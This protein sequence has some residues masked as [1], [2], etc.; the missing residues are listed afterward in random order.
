MQKIY[1]LVHICLLSNFWPLLY[2]PY[3]LNMEQYVVYV[4]QYVTKLLFCVITKIN[5]R[6]MEN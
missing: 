6:M 2:V 3:L 4:L 1:F 5:I